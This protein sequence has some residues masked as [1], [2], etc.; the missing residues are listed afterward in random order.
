M[1]DLPVIGNKLDLIACVTCFS[2]LIGLQPQRNADLITKSMA[3]FSAL[4]GLLKYTRFLHPPENAKQ[5]KA[6]VEAEW[7]SRLVGLLHALVLIVGSILCFLEWPHYE[8]DEAYTVTNP[9]KYYNPEIFASIFA[10]YLQYDLLWLLWH[11]KENFD[12]ASI[13]HHILYIAITHYVLWGRFFVKAYA[14]LSFGE[15]STPFLHL[16]WF[17]AVMDWKDNKWYTVS[18]IFFAITFLFTRVICYGLGLVDIWLSKSVWFQLPYGFHAVV[19]GVHLGYVLNLFWA[20]KV[21][22]ALTKYTGMSRSV[23]KK[24]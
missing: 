4:Y 8:G 17:F 20:G 12:M 9:D 21:F 16:R 11:K 14:W 5:L 18:S 24:K 23:T 2:Y 22:G 1:L 7:R 6:H 19:F 13:I 3:F 15:L 10:G